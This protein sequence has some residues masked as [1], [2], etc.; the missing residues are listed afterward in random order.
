[1]RGIASFLLN[2]IPP[3]KALGSACPCDQTLRVAPLRPISGTCPSSIVFWHF[4][5][6]KLACAIFIPPSV[7][8]PSRAGALWRS[9]HHN[10]EF[11]D[12]PIRGGQMSIAD[13][14]LPEFDQEM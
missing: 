13:A 9:R 6:R 2:L 1:M 14:L 5:Q 12:T 10:T 3:K 11:D 8:Q 4:G 7:E